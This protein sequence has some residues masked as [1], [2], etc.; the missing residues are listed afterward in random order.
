MRKRETK[1]PNELEHPGGCRDVSRTSL[2]VHGKR[3]K[4][5]P[6]QWSTIVQNRYEFA[7]DLLCEDAQRPGLE[8]T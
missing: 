8:V 7:V 2:A 5:R 1:R 3:T 6:V 4:T